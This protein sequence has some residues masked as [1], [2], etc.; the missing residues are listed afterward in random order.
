MRRGTR[1]RMRSRTRSGTTSSSPDWVTKKYTCSSGDV[2]CCDNFDCE[3]ETD[4][5]DVYQITSVSDLSITFSHEN[6]P[7]DDL[8]K[9]KRQQRPNRSYILEPENLDFFVSE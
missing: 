9:V 5:L 8:Y 3:N 1:A 7:V 4:Y 2:Y 6:D